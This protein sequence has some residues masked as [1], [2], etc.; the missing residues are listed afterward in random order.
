MD[1]EIEVEQR[2]GR[3]KIEPTSMEPKPEL[4]PIERPQVLSIRT[5][6]AL[7]SQTIQ[8]QLVEQREEIQKFLRAQ[9]YANIELLD[10][11]KKEDRLLLEGLKYG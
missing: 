10:K 2:R 11:K 8:K 7:H 5:W 4:R 6:I 3:K 9:Y 1:G